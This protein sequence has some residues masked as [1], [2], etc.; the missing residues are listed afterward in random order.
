MKFSVPKEFERAP[1]IQGVNLG[2]VIIALVNTIMAIMLLFRSN[3]KGAF[4][5]LCI[6]AIGVYIKS[7]F[8]EKGSLIFIVTDFFKP[9]KIVQHNTIKSLLQKTNIK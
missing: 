5:F 6:G 8:K 9:K 3:I 7:K 1:S 4:I 2:I